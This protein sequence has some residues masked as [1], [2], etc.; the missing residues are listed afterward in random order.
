MSTTKR[1]QRRGLGVFFWSLGESSPHAPPVLFLAVD[2]WTFSCLQI[3]HRLSA[4]EYLDVSV[5][6]ARH[7]A[8]ISWPHTAS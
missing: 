7:D 4:H 8:H 3:L 2:D 5:V 1:L 6:S